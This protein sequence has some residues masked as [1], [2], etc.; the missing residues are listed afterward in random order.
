MYDKL[1][2]FSE[3]SRYN[4]IEWR[5]H[6]IGFITSGITYQYVK[7]VFPD[8]SVL[9]LGISYP[10]PESKIRNFAKKLK[11]VCV[12]EELDPFIEEQIKIMGIRNYKS[13]KR[14]NF[15]ELTPEILDSI[16]KNRKFTL[17]RRFLIA[18]MHKRLERN[19]T[20]FSLLYGS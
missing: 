16:K 17:I 13:F 6:N 8:S 3:K 12:I 9:K 20:N 1:K 7:E 15:G 11:R 14:P 2:Y 10:L 4:K 18:L 5:K 19:F